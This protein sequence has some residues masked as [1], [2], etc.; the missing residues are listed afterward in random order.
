MRFLNNFNTVSMN[1]LYLIPARKGSKTLPGKNIK[2]LNGKPLI[3]YTIDAARKVSSDKNICVSTN[4][5]D[6]IKVVE[7]YGLKVP[8]LRP[9]NLATDISTTED[10]ILHALEFYNLKGKLFDYVVLLQPTSPLRNGYHLQRALK[11]ITPDTEMIVS[12]KVTDA[13]PYYVLLEEN[14]KGNLVGSKTA[15]FTR[16]QDCPEVY[17]LNGAIYIINVLKLLEKGIANM[18]KKK[19]LMDKASS[20]D[21][22]D[23]IDFEIAKVIMSRYFNIEN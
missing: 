2:D 5:F 4:D 6:I 23:N 9:E 22:D 8:F 21:I 15:N 20:I 3:Y 17:E 1:I 19:Y 11:L 16:R 7:A 10:V 14:E 18:S 12:V 13:N